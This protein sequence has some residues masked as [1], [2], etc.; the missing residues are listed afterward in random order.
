MSGVK[1]SKKV[2]SSMLYAVG[3]DSKSKTL[4]VIFNKGG[5]WEYYDVP[6]D[7]YEGL[8]RSN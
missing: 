6:K 1:N 2:K 4:E 7:E 3:Y 5:I 8:M